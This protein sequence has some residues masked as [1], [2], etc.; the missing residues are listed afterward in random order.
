MPLARTTR[1]P[2]HSELEAGNGW[3]AQT[4]Y[5]SFSQKLLRHQGNLSLCLR[6]LRFSTRKKGSSTTRVKTVASDKAKV[7]KIAAITTS[8]SLYVTSKKAMT[9]Y[10]NGTCTRYNPKEM[11]PRNCDIGALRST[12]NAEDFNA[13][14]TNSAAAITG[15]TEAGWPSSKSLGATS[16]PNLSPSPAAGHPIKRPKISATD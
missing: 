9:V 7:R 10:S 4:V 14:N 5:G 15:Q 13:A 2:P 12:V 11:R 1:K 3:L 8:G 16:N 6:L